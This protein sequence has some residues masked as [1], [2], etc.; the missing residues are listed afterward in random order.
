MKNTKFFI[1]DQNNSG[2]RFV[3]DSD[4]G[5]G[6]IVFIEAQNAKEANIR[7]VSAGIHFDG[8]DDGT[9][10]EC[11]GDR[12]RRVY[13]SECG[14]KNNLEEIMEWLNDRYGSYPGDRVTYIHYL[15]GSI[16]LADMKI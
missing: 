15:D 13:D 14:C 5:I 16:A 10:C 7:A 2:G 12:W 9:D 11:C 3:I 8:V 4:A 1:F 6:H